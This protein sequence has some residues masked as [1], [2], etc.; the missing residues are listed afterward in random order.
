MFKLAPS[1]LNIMQTFLSDNGLRLKLC[2]GEYFP[3][4]SEWCVFVLKFLK[5][6]PEECP[7]VSFVIHIRCVFIDSVLESSGCQVFVFIVA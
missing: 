1:G 2:T 4:D 3:C 5:I 6:V 7:L